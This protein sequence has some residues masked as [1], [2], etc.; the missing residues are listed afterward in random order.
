MRPSQERPSLRIN[1]H[2]PLGVPVTFRHNRQN[3]HAARLSLA[4]VCLMLVHWSLLCYS[5]PRGCTRKILRNVTGGT[6]KPYETPDKLEPPKSP[7]N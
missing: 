2:K 7:K 4:R 6:P 5:C 1:D 3:K